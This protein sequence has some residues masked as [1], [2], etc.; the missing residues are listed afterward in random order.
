MIFIYRYNENLD[1][2]MPDLPVDVRNGFLEWLHQFHN[3]IDGSDSWY[4]TSVTTLKEYHECEGNSLIKWNKG[5]YKNVF[6]LICDKYV[7]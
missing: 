3:S 5:G 7:S 2:K 6:K 4:Q 1:S